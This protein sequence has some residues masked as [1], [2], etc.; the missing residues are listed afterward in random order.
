MRKA[1]VASRQLD[2]PEPEVVELL[3][4]VGVERFRSGPLR[5]GLGSWLVLVLALS[6]PRALE[7]SRRVL[8]LPLLLFFVGVEMGLVESPLLR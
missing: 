6:R 2:P 8:R 4:R 1:E 5:A 3:L 7:L